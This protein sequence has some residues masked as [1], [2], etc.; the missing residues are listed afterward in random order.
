MSMETL[1]ASLEKWSR[2]LCGR[3]FLIILLHCAKI[4]SHTSHCMFSQ[5]KETASDTSSHCSIDKVVWGKGWSK[6]RVKQ[7][8]W[9]S[10]S[11]SNIAGWIQTAPEAELS[12]A[13]SCDRS[14]ITRWINTCVVKVKWCYVVRC[15]WTCHVTLHDTDTFFCPSSFLCC[16]LGWGWGPTMIPRRGSSTEAFIYSASEPSQLTTDICPGCSLSI[17]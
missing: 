9:I 15:Y 8:A 11:P 14:M 10:L 4:I 16:R 1:I 6:D 17:Y 2:G 3:F 7:K 13:L 12:R 5:S